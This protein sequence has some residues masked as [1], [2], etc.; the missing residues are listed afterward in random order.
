MNHVVKAQL[1]GI[2]L[3]IPILLS[4]AGLGYGV[5]C[6]QKELQKMRPKRKEKGKGKRRVQILL[7]TVHQLFYCF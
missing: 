7:T 1:F 3:L 4:I 2:F 6:S 5:C